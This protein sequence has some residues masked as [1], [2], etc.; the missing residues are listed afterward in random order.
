MNFLYFQHSLFDGM[1]SVEANLFGLAAAMKRKW[2]KSQEAAENL[3]SG[4][5]KELM[6]ETDDFIEAEIESARKE[7]LAKAENVQAHLHV[8]DKFG[9]TRIKEMKVH[10]DTF[11][12]ICIQ[13]AA[14]KA[15]GRSE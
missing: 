2:G 11:L 7:L 1:V 8:F 4:L 12:Q 3:G 13:V 10:P 5:I 14:F 9:K 15:H 6:V